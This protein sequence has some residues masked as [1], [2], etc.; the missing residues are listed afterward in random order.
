MER[1][2]FLKGLAALTS[3]IGAA[4]GG[5]GGEYVSG[6]GAPLPMRALGAAGEQVTMLG[7]G[8]YHVGWTTESDARETIEAALE[9][10]VR[11][12]DTAESYGD[13]ESESRYGRYLTPRYR[14]D[15]F[16]MTKST[17]RTGAEAR[18]HLEGSLRR[19][20]TDHLDLWQVHSLRDP[21]DVDQRIAEGVLDVFEQARREGKTRFIGFTGHRNPA[22]HLRMLERTAER[23]I[24]DTCQ[25]PI[26]VLDPSKLSFIQGVLPVLLQRKI[27]PLAMKT[28][29]DGRFFPVKR[30]LGEVRWETDS[31]VI[32][33]RI[34]VQDALFFSWSLPI[35]VLITGAENADLMREKIQLAR[36]F[37]E[38]DADDRA[39]LIDKVSDLAQD[40]K[41]E[42]FKE[43]L[44]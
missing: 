44:A 30:V 12:F 35:S 10:G 31:P 40:L 26:N 39:A 42:Y 20:K 21:E 36:N 7:T 34:S 16:L 32:P 14:D 17:A 27:A 9:G 18:E 19:L 29:A 5:S 41:V 1:R 24:F 13:G 8:G 15:I 38:L 6:E 2:N 33:N 43:E 11:F 25:M 37:V 28:L 4:C 23:P 3:S 22:A